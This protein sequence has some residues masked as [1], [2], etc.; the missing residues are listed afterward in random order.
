MHMVLDM[1]GDTG[2]QSEWYPKTPAPRILFPSIRFFFPRRAHVPTFG[3]AR[4]HLNSHV[5]DSLI[6][7]MGSFLGWKC[8]KKSVNEH[9]LRTWLLWELA[10]E[11]TDQKVA[12]KEHIIYRGI[13]LCVGVLTTEKLEHNQQ[14]HRD[15]TWELVVQ[16]QRR[17]TKQRDWECSQLP[18]SNLV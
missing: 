5:C 3:F 17:S 12:L 10:G 13:Q 18:R 11:R 7:S 4:C 9:L 1:Y 2:R 16:G 6:K 8:Q 14:K 15:R